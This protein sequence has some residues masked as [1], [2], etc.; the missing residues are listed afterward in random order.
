M[1]LY[2]NL[3]KAC[4]QWVMVAKALTKVGSEVRAMMYKVVVKT[5]LLYKSES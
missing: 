4:R 5:V 2:Q 1:A 3:K